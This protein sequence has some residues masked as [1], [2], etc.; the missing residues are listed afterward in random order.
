MFFGLKT[1]FVLTVICFLCFGESGKREA[2]GGT[3]LKAQRVKLKAEGS[4]RI[5]RSAEGMA[6]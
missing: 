1:C 2:Y 4:M 5:G 3:Q 6:E